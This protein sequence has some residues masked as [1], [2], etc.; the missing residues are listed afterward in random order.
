MKTSSTPQEMPF[1]SESG[2]INNVQKKYYTADEAV[3]FLEPRIRAMFKWKHWKFL[4]ELNLSAELL[5]YVEIEKKYQLTE[6]AVLK[7]IDQYKDDPI[8]QLLIAYYLACKN[9]EAKTNDI[10]NKQ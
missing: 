7:V 8:A 9:L 1:G 4:K 6:K 2:S 3:A 5:S 10:P